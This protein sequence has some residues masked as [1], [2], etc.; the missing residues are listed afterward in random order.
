MEC[1]IIGYNKGNHTVIYYNI[2]QTN[3]ESN[4]RKIILEGFFVMIFLHVPNQDSPV[5]GSSNS[6]PPY[7]SPI[8]LDTATP[9]L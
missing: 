3:M 8:W 1:K 5:L 2:I 4:K 6:Q 7:C 9:S